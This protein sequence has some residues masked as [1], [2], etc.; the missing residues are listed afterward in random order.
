MLAG[1]HVAS[2]P[3]LL[4]QPAQQ[5]SPALHAEEAHFSS[6]ALGAFGSQQ[7]L[8]AVAALQAPEHGGHTVG[9]EV[10]AAATNW[11]PAGAAGSLACR[12][13]HGRCA[14]GSCGA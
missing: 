2:A 14:A 6:M 12:S 7:N 9:G 10:A 1:S 11:E 4:Q 5:A 13:E 8:A 3:L